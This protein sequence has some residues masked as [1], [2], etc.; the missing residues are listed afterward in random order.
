MRSERSSASRLMQHGCKLASVS[1]MPGCHQPLP[2]H[3]QPQ[4]ECMRLAFRRPIGALRPRLQHLTL[5]TATCAAGS[6][7]P[8]PLATSARSRRTFLTSPL[9]PERCC[10]RK[11]DPTQVVPSQCSLRLP[12]SPCPPNTSA[13][14][15]CDGC[16]WR[17][18]TVVAEA[19]STRWATTVCDV[20]CVGVQSPPT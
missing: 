18:A 20:R 4:H 2:P 12:L 7:L 17:R 10:S 6:E 19:A 16:V 8:S 1:R 15:F 9:R 5:R 13:C 14:S 11:L 3:A